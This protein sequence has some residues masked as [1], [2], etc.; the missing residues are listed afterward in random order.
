MTI[1]EI[2]SNISTHMAKGLLIHNQIASLYGFLNLKGYQKCHEYHYYEETCNYRYLQ[3]FFLSHCNKMIH[4]NSI[5]QPDIIPNNWYKFTKKEVDVNNKRSAVKD[6]MKKW[7]EWEKET[8]TLLES[9]YKQLYELNEISCAIEIM[10]FIK[11]VDKELADAQE[12]YINLESMGYDIVYIID[13]QPDLYTQ[14]CKK[15]K[16]IHEGDED[17]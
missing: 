12:T 13:R 16:E 4:E 15:I 3:N 10:Y 6:L 14:Y 2:F 5:E 9:S 7:V 1:E 17:D 8:K 11:D